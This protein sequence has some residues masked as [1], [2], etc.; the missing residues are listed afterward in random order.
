MANTDKVVCIAVD[1]GNYNIK[2]YGPSR[3]TKPF[4]TGV[5]HHGEVPPPMLNGALKFRG[6]YYSI[7][8][9]RLQARRN[10][11]N[12]EDYMV[13]TLAAIARE[14]RAEWPDREKHECRVGLALG[15]PVEHLSLKVGG[16]LL[17]DRYKEYFGNNGLPLEFEYE[18]EQY[19]IQIVDVSVFPQTISAAASDASVWRK[20]VG[21]PRSY[22][23]DIGGG[24]TNVIG[25]IN[26]EPQNPGI[27]LENAGVLQLFK[28]VERHVMEDCGVA[29][30]DFMVDS[31]L[32][33][34]QP[35]PDDIRES[36][37]NAS[38]EFVKKRINDLQ[39]GRGVDMRMGQLCFVGGGSV[40]LF[41]LF[42][43]LLKRSDLILI[44]DV[45]ANAKGYYYQETTKLRRNGYLVYSNA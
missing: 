24:T 37:C 28:E 34:I 4:P 44:P 1:Q 26:G 39:D 42:Q 45:R 22:I 23:V 29:L 5:N 33:G 11:T 21:S 9:S 10:K 18:G 17:K 32:R 16:I 12:D 6:K 31:V 7:C 14:L 40:L 3:E 19:R 2:S 25:I 20:V 41:E 38:T 35:C 36:I 27:T 13:L 43:T 30:D 15:L 8:E